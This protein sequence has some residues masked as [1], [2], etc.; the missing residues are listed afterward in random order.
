MDVVIP[1]ADEP[2]NHT[3]ALAIESIRTHAPQ[4]RIVLLGNT[5]AWAA[6]VDL[7]FRLDQLPSRPLLNTDNAMLF[8]CRTEA[9]SDPFLW[10]NDDIYW[11][12]PVAL[13]ELVKQSGTA[14]GQLTQHSARGMYGVTAHRTHGLLVDRGL[15]TFSYERHVPLLVSKEAMIDVLGSVERGRFA[16]RS[17]YQNT[18]LPAPVE[19]RPAGLGIGRDVKVFRAPDPIPDL[20]REPFLSTGNNYP[21]GGVRELLG[22]AAK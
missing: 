18:V 9:I 14:W 1:V 21:L 12:R 4:L 20:D 11:R 5:A 3:L 16:K 7:A 13:P 22:L 2:V 8:A 17:V 6:R 19:L 15:P 10:S